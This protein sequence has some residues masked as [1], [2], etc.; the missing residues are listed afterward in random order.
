MDLGN[1]GWQPFF[2]NQITKLTDKPSNVGRII[3][4]QRNYFRLLGKDGEFLAKLS[5]A[6]TYNLRDEFG[7]PVVGDWVVYSQAP[8]DET[9]II[10][11]LLKRQNAISRVAAGTSGTKDSKGR[12]QVM[13]ANVDTVFIVSGLDR[14]FNPR[15][16]ERYLTLVY[17]SQAMP[18]IVLNKADLCD[19]PEEKRFEIESIAVGVPVLLISAQSDECVAMIRPYLM[20]GYTAALLGSSGVGK[21][22]LINALIGTDR[23]KVRSISEQ[24]GKGTHTTTNR[25]LILLPGGGMIIDTPGMRE[26]QLQ[27]CEEGLES[28]FNEI[29]QLASRCRFSDCSHVSEPGCAVIKA[30]SDGTIDSA[31]LENYLKLRKE[32]HYLSERETKSSKTIEKEK[33]KK[34]KIMVKNKKKFD[35]L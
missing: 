19:D 16:I 21:S 25:E 13:V 30:I 27:D 24:V 2:A 28:S 31:R 5:G 34:I 4:V 7:V 29:D 12:V 10:K 18:V 11:S 32:M 23:Q 9:A 35:R 22:T 33:W 26:L 6:F 17:E 20:P 3:D 15:R 1:L 14:D 8:E